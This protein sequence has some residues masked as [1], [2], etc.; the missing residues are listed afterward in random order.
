MMTFIIS[1]REL[2]AA[3]LILPPSMQTSSTYIYS[4]FEQGNLSLGMAM[5]VICV[6]ITIIMLVVTNKISSILKLGG[7]IS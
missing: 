5:A 4:Q 1:F 2:V 3:L 6:I 7:I